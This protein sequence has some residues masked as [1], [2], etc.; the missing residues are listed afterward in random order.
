MIASLIALSMAAAA[1]CRRI[2]Q[3][4]QI[5]FTPAIARPGDRVKLSFT[6]REGVGDE[7]PVPLYCVTKAR[8]RGRAALER[9]FV[10]RI[11][12]DARPGSE[13]VAV[14]LIGETEVSLTLHVAGEVQAP[15][16]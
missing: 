5:H 9:N 1:D 4:A 6:Y 11:T 15:G 13:V 3:E 2:G 7:K 14:A 16:A 8:V 10:V 12:G